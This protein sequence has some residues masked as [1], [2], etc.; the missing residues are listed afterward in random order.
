MGFVGGMSSV[1]PP[2]IPGVEEL[3]HD[4]GRRRWHMRRDV[5]CRFLSRCSETR[6]TPLKSTGELG[7]DSD[8]HIRAPAL[9]T[10]IIR[11]PFA[12]EPLFVHEKF[13]TQE[14]SQTV[15]GKTEVLTIQLAGQPDKHKNLVFVSAGYQIQERAKFVADVRLCYDF[16]RGEAGGTL[17]S[18]PWDRYM[19]LTNVFAVFQPSVDS[20]ASYPKGQDGG[21]GLPA[22]GTEVALAPSPSLI[23]SQSLCLAARAVLKDSPRRPP[24]ANHRP[25]PTTNRRPPT[26]NRQPPPTANRQPP[27]TANRQLPPTSN[28]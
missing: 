18:A 1:E 26:A 4:G 17:M 16:L 24:T 20:G 21:G 9:E 23:S 12:Q 27:P 28:L 8:P 13:S 14:I 22:D 7:L 3:S 19:P 5:W 6:E 25:L 11:L 2:Q 15:A 10:H